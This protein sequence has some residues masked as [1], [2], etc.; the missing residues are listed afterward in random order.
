MAAQAERWNHNLHYHRVILDTVPDRAGGPSTSA[1][2]REAWPATCG[3]WF[4]TSWPPSCFRARF[5]R[6]LLWRYSLVWSKPA[7]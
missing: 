5:R 2:A 4:R 1:A 3:G 7:A 6:H